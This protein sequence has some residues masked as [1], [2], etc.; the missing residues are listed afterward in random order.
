MRM[1]K[2][3]MWEAKDS[4]RGVVLLEGEQDLEK[5]LC[6]CACEEKSTKIH[7]IVLLERE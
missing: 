7:D 3:S 5:K 2:M 1:Y 6:V 4:T